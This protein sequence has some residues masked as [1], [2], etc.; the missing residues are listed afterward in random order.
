MKAE[1]VRT[2]RGLLLGIIILTSGLVLF[3]AIAVLWEPHGKELILNGSFEAHPE[4][5][6]PTPGEDVKQGYKLLCGGSST[7]S[8]WQVV[9]QRSPSQDC[10]N[11]SDAVIWAATPNG[12]A[13][14]PDTNIAAY[15]GQHALDLTGFVS[16]PPTRCGKGQ[17]ECRARG[18]ERPMI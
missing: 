15:D 3:A 8:D 16:K 5:L 14:D 4:R 7:L 2:S 18:K 17:Q 6:V 1:A 9:K 13:N 10:T 11:A 12:L